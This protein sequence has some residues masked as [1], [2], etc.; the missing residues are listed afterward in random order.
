VG[1]GEKI[2]RIEYLDRLHGSGI[3][4]HLSK[5]GMMVCDRSYRSLLYSVN[6]AALQAAEVAVREIDGGLHP[7]SLGEPIPRHGGARGRLARD[8]P[9]LANR[10]KVK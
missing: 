7:G 5:R 3:N 2:T 9:S 1:E 6:R 10:S 4:E 8:S